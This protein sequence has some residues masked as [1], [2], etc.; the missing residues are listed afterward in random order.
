MRIEEKSG[1]LKSSIQIGYVPKEGGAEASRRESRKMSLIGAAIGAKGVLSA[2]G[3]MRKKKHT[4]V[5]DSRVVE[6]RE[7]KAEDEEEERGVEEEKKREEKVEE[8]KMEEAEALAR[9]REMELV[10]EEGEGGGEEEFAE[11]GSIK[12][13]KIGGIVAALDQDYVVA[14]G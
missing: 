9:F 12:L 10:E 5:V 3:K 1:Y 6:E 2:L 4:I 8:K 11:D 14:I 13:P 7:R